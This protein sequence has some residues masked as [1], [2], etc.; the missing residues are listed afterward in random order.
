MI[1]FTD[2]LVAQIRLHTRAVLSLVGPSGYPIALPLPFVFD[3]DKGRFAMPM[4]RNLPNTVPHNG[5]ASLTL[6]RY[7][8]QAANERW[9]LFHG[10]LVEQV[11]GF[12]FYPSRVVTPSWG[13]R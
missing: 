8:A 7:D 10:R 2:E 12:E 3:R 13:R 6:L 9:L 11:S 1:V 4:P 5:L